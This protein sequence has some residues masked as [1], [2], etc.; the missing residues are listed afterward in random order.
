MCSKLPLPNAV[1]PEGLKELL[2]EMS[3][4]SWQLLEMV[5]PLVS[6]TICDAPFCKE[7]HAKEVEPEW[8]EDLAD[9]R[10]V[11]YRPILF[12]SYE[13]KVSQKGWVG[14]TARTIGAKLAPRDGSAGASDGDVKFKQ[15]RK[16]RLKVYYVADELALNEPS[17]AINNLPEQEHTGATPVNDLP[18]QEPPDDDDDTAGHYFGLRPL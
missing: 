2:E 5:P 1:P 18:E 6:E 9:Y 16:P 10:L 3:R 12:F 13:G 7:W 8:N 11:Y 14:N 4:L 15:Y 17:T